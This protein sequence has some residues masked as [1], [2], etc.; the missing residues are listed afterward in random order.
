MRR[1]RL[2]PSILGSWV[3]WFYCGVMESTEALPLA[4][5]WCCEGFGV[6]QRGLVPG[7]WWKV[8]GRDVPSHLWP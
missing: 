2:A 6:T 7:G 3:F 5:V 8:P 4:Q 1:G